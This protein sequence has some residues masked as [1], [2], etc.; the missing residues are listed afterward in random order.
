MKAV[1]NP[2][3]DVASLDLFSGHPMLAPA[4]IDAARQ[5]KYRPYILNGNPVHMETE[6]T[7]NFA[8]SQNE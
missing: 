3:G 6:V 2:T 1:I 7:V 4:A 8:L 5:W